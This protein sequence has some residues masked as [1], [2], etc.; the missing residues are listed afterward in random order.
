MQRGGAKGR[1]AVRKMLVVAPSSVIKNWGQEIHKW[2]GMERAAY[3][4]LLPGKEAAGQVLSAAQRH[5]S[6]CLQDDGMEILAHA[7]AQG[8]HPRCRLLGKSMSIR[9]GQTCSAID[10]Q[11]TAFKSGNKWRIL[12]ASYENIRKHC[13]LLQGAIDLLVCD[14]GHRLKS[15]AGNSTMA[16]LLTLNCPRR[17]ILTGTPVQNNLKEFFAMMNFVNPGLLGVQSTFQRV[18]AAP[19]EASREADA[20][21]EACKLGAARAAELSRIIEPFQLR[22]TA[23]INKKYLP[24]CLRYVV[25]CR[26]TQAQLGAYERVLADGSMLDRLLAQRTPDGTQ[27]LSIIGKLRQVCNHPELASVP[28]EVRICRFCTFR[29]SG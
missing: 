20:S 23:D 19:I 1:P 16:A 29:H 3:L 27:V 12:I 25:F 8:W 6:T 10:V 15:A 18:F 9:T 13:A 24:P 28:T 14:E 17:V 11:V 7:F 2:L 4:V 26:P 21:P 5:A 22:R